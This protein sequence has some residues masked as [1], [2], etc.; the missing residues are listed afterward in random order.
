MAKTTAAPDEQYDIIDF[1]KLAVD[2]VAPNPL[3]PRPRFHLGDDDPEILALRTSIETE[4]QHRPCAV[5]ELMGHWERPDSPGRYV[6]LQGE[7]RWMAV[8]GST[9]VQT[10]KCVIHPAPVSL[11]QELELLSVEDAHRLSWQAFYEMRHAVH[12]AEVYGVSVA[13]VDIANK[14]GLTMDQLRIAERL[15]KLD[16]SVLELVE[17]YE[18]TMY[19][20]RKSGARPARSRL[21][22]PGRKAIEFTPRKGAL[23]YDIFEALRTNLT[24]SVQGLD[25]ADLQMRIATWAT[26]GASTEDL[27]RLLSSIRSC[28]ENPPPGMLAKVHAMVKDPTSAVRGAIKGL[29]NSRLED[30]ATLTRRGEVLAKQAAK[31]T[32]HGDQFGHDPKLLAEIR[33]SLLTTIRSFERLERIVGERQSEVN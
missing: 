21:V 3:N 27:E 19:A 12:I 29:G 18:K 11:A 24:L 14:T 1:E 32:K 5:Y 9:K 20:Q 28:G 26:N 13:H 22:G 8:S 30:L 6:L 4:G 16:S 23:V 33:T 25:D 15:F 17:A 31:L 7:R 2:I 10:L